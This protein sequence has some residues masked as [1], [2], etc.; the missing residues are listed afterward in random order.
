[1]TLTT[2]KGM[3]FFDGQ[4]HFDMK[5]YRSKL[6][7]NVHLAVP[8][9]GRKMGKVLASRIVQELADS[10]ATSASR[11]TEQIVARQVQG[12]RF[13]SASHRRAKER[14]Q[15]RFE[16]EKLIEEMAEDRRR[17][18][19]RNNPDAGRYRPSGDRQRSPNNC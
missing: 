7:I 19:Q 4:I 2:L 3:G 1:M 14:R 6:V 8:K 18:W 10:L 9:R 5:K 12:K 15:S 16:R 11:R 13:K 17:K